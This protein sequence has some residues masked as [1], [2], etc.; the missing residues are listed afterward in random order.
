MKVLLA[1]DG[2]PNADMCVTTICEG[3]L[4]KDSIVHSI[5][6]HDPIQSRLFPKR[7]D[8]ERAENIVTLAVKRIS[9]A[10]PECVVTG[11][12]LKGHPVTRI[13]QVME[14]FEPDVLLMGAH[15]RTSWRDDVLGKTSNEVLRRSSC[16]VVLVRADPNEKTKK[17]P[18]HLLCFDDTLVTLEAFSE[19]ERRIWPPESEF[20]VLHVLIDLFETGSNNP[21]IDA[22]FA[23][24]RMVER[25]VLM[26]KS[27]EDQVTSLT[28]SLPGHKITGLVVPES[29]GGP[30]D[31]ILNTAEEIEADLIVMGSHQR[32]GIDRFWLGSVSEA[33]AEHAHCSVEII[34]PM[35]NTEVEEEK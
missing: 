14:S 7:L 11:A 17:A 34:R 27:V 9:D 5:A 2:S 18:R 12:T 25:K 26:E 6:I 20:V 31:T 24:R 23:Q 33:V 3:P 16:S 35:L 30:V 4:D 32:K 8:E 1:T 28:R 15:A 10:H 22:E 29:F 13:L 21:E 19:L